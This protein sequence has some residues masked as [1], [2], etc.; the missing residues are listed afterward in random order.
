MEISTDY[1]LTAKE[2]AE[3]K[4]WENKKDVLMAP[5][6]RRGLQL[7]PGSIQTAFHRDLLGLIPD[8]RTSR[9][10]MAGRIVAALR[11]EM[12]ERLCRSSDEVVG[13]AQRTVHCS[14]FE[15]AIELP[16][17]IEEGDG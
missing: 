4:V 1:V 5:L 12:A 17:Q 9:V 6:P 14:C 7:E 11:P 8:P 3:L 13:H 16:R 2:R 10:G 15:A